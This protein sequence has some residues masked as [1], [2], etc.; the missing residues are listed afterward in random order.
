LPKPAAEVVE[1]LAE[2][3]ILAGVPV[4]RLHPQRPELVNLL[5]VAAS[6]CTTKDDM[7]ALETGLKEVLR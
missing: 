6:E 4:S 5:L 1:R 7:D 2:R 3:Q